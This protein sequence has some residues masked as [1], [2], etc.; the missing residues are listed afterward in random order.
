MPRCIVHADL[1]AFYA[2]VEQRDNPALRGQPV[3][4]GG[5]PEHR[6][7]V[8]TASYEA[9]RFG[10]HSAMAMSRALRLC[11]GAV[12]V[13]PRFSVYAEVSAVVLETYRSR[14][15][16]VEPLALDEAYLDLSEQTAEDDDWRSI[17]Q[18]IKETVRSAVGLTV[19]V[20]IAA[21]K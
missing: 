14:T 9:R 19:S 21:S 8:A 15:P 11:P 13:P 6:G 5:A 2:S 17:G 7:V 4:V 10:V 12:R 18:E 20:G 3:I 1:D 16:L